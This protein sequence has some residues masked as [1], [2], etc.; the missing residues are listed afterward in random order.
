MASWGRK[1]IWTAVLV[2]AM[3]ALAAC[4]TNNNAAGGKTFKQRMRRIQ[5]QQAIHL[6]M[7]VPILQPIMAQG[8]SSGNSERLKFLLVPSGW[9]GSMWR[10]T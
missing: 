9:Q 2:L 4:G 8:L 1:C 6:P 10:I 5:P 3:S 7:Q